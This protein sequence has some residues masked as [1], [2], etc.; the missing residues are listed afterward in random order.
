MR[1]QKT[2]V[3]L[4]LLADQYPLKKELMNAVKFP[5]GLDLWS[6]S[7]TLESKEVTVDKWRTFAPVLVV[8]QCHCSQWWPMSLQYRTPDNSINNC[9]LVLQTDASDFISYS[10][11]EYSAAKIRLDPDICWIRSFIK[12]SYSSSK[13]RVTKAREFRFMCWKLKCQHAIIWLILSQQFNWLK[14]TFKK[15]KLIINS[16]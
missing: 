4:S 1:R 10:S 3:D 8:G 14:S 2:P 9:L 6:D 12:A 15:N 5:T 16:L 13:E 7:R 11:L